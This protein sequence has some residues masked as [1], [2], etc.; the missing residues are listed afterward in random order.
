VQGSIP[1]LDL[2]SVHKDPMSKAKYTL[3]V[4]V[5]GRLDTQGTSASDLAE[6]RRAAEQAA[7]KL[8]REGEEAYY[9][10]GPSRSM[11]LIG[12]FDETEYDESHP[13]AGD[14]PRLKEAR[15]KF[16]YNLVN[17]AGYKQTRPGA[18]EGSLQRSQ[19]V[20]IPK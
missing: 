9:F 13:G 2:R 17:G 19:V 1:E 5:Y 11:V 14:G 12:A 10:H 8:R 15:Q 6:F 16:P 18:T 7:A 4:G 3:Q 20:M